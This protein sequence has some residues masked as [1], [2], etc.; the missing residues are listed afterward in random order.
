MAGDDFATGYLRAE[1]DLDLRHYDAAERGYR[2]A[3][4]ERPDF[5]FGYYGLSLAQLGLGR[6]EAAATFTRVHAA[7]SQSQAGT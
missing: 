7:Q 2:H 6:P 1:A 5:A 4:D 3:V